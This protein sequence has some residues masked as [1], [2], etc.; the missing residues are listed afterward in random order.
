MAL[1]GDYS[2]AGRG[3]PSSLP[4]GGR[5]HAGSSFRR[6]LPLVASHWQDPTFLP[7]CLLV[8]NSDR[9]DLG[10]HIPIP[11]PRVPPWGGG[12]A[13]G[14]GW[15]ATKGLPFHLGWCNLHVRSLPLSSLAGWWAFP[16]VRLQG[17]WHHVRLGNLPGVARGVPVQRKGLDLRTT[18]L[19][20]CDNSHRTWLGTNVPRL[21]IDPPSRMGGGTRDF[22][23][24]L[25]V[26]RGEVPGTAGRVLNNLI[27]STSVCNVKK[28]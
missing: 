20:P 15:V 2:H 10:V 11:W 7:V 12:M 9:V 23:H 22:L 5:L 19:E 17:A 1:W 24:L 8:R 26:A 21:H 6:S 14:F 4:D 3:A 25:P 18:V 13:M 28:L 27:F 16:G